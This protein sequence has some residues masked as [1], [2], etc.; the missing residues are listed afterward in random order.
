MLS[1][2]AYYITTLKYWEEHRDQFHESHWVALDHTKSHHAIDEHGRIQHDHPEHGNMEICVVV[3]ADE[4]THHK[5]H[6]HENFKPLPHPLSGQQ[7]P[8]HHLVKL[9]GHSGKFHGKMRTF[10]LANELAKTNHAM[11][12]RTF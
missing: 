3:A 8:E 4:G 10:D 12:Y 11:G 1:S 5:L 2:R 7:V 6:N 9:K